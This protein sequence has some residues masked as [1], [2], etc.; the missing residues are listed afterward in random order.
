M[1]RLP[2]PVTTPFSI[3]STIPGPKSSVWIPSPYAPQMTVTL[4]GYRRPP[5]GCGS[6]R[7]HLG[8]LF[9]D[10]L[11]FGC[12]SGGPS[13]EGDMVFYNCLHFGNMQKRISEYAGHVLIYFH[14]S[15]PQCLAAVEV[16]SLAVPKL[17]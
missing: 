1:N 8:N 3:I 9:A 11:I 6:V 2:A 16:K 5:A 7:H 14:M 13:P 17:K 12:G 10:P 15:F 4:F